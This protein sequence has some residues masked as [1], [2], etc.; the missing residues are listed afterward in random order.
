[1]SRHDS[2]HL[3]RFNGGLHMPDEKAL[4]SGAAI[5][6][7]PLPKRLVLPLKQHIGEA[8]KPLVAVGERVLKGQIIARAEGYISAPV[9]APSSG[10]IAAI[11]EMPIPHPSGLSARC[12][13][14]DTDGEDEWR[15]RKPVGDSYRELAPLELRNILRE[16]G[17]VGLGGATFPSAVKLQPGPKKPIQTLVIN[18]AECE[19]YITC[20]QLL[21]RDR[22]DEVVAGIAIVQHTVT[23]QHT[24]IGIEDNKP[25][26]ISAMRAAVSAAGL[27]NTEVVVVPT[28]YPTGGEKQLIRVLTGKLVPSNGLPA[29]V[30]V[31]CH[32]V[33]TCA[34]IAAAVYRDEPLISRIVTVTGRGIQTPQNVEVPIGVA[35]SEVVAHCGGYVDGVERLVMGGP[36]MGFAL[37]TDELPVVK[38]CNCL[39]ATVAEELPAAQAESPCI[40]CGACVEACP[41]ELMPQQLYWYSRAKDFE[42]AQQ[43]HLFDCIECGCCAYVCPSHIPLVQYYR[44]A[45]TEIAAAERD[46]AQAE[47]ARQRHDFRQ[48]RIDKAAR[49][50]AEKLA[51]KKALLE[52]SKKE[53]A[54]KKAAAEAAGDSAPAESDPKQDAIKAAIERAKQKKAAAG[55]KPKNTE[56]LT[57]AQQAKIAAADARRAQASAPQADNDEAPPR[58]SAES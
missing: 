37:F 52:A 31:L 11:E 32:N 53:A 34:A 57:E 56:N 24:L 5:S 15:E 50:K 8:T 14:I 33:G 38:G 58:R 23:P 41:A 28:R 22:A 27:E 9:H 42:Q 4:S 43:Y 13:A 25:D 17:L 10:T 35:M 51:K 20:D 44:F 21:M 36:M 1:M 12:I 49:E 18:G 40:R 47:I 16:H 26:S 29:D 39:L 6:Q 3:W 30:G 45:K 7:L 46:K 55:V 2:K 48:E 19:P 54:A